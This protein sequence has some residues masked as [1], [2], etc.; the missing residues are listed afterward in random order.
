MRTSA[1]S[2]PRTSPT[3]PR[4]WRRSPGSSTRRA[5]GRTSSS[6]RSGRRASSPSDLAAVVGRGGLLVP[7]PSGVYRVNDRMLEDLYQGR[8]GRARL[9]P[10]RPDRRRDRPSAG[11]PRLHRRSRRRGRARRLGPA[12]RRPGHPA[13]QHLPRPE[14]QVFGPPGRPQ[15]RPEL[16]VAQPHRL[17]SR[18][19]H[20]RSAPTG[21]AGS[22]TST[23]ASNGEG[24]I[25]PERAGTVPAGDLVALAFSGKI[26]GGGPQ[27]D[28]DRPGRDGRPPQD[29]RH[30]G[31][32]QARRRGRQ[33]GR[34]SSSRPWPTPW[35]SRSGPAP[36]SSR[37]GWTASS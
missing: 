5:S 19:R 17:P 11:P 20:H 31:D 36:P 12:Q 7:I 6:R 14:P 23:T 30:A 8:P 13:P 22:W 10:G 37:A 25:T 27:E 1:R 29:E 28:D 3:P 9:E 4:S 21:T 15:A 33:A 26:R 16:R 35:P 32:A 34:R 24:P 18:R 2:C